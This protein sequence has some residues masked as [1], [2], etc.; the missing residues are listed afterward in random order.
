MKSLKHVLFIFGLFLILSI[1]CKKEEASNIIQISQT[2]A[3][4]FKIVASL[5][6]NNQPKDY[7]WALS[8]NK[9]I[10]DSLNTPLDDNILVPSNLL[11][12]FKIPN[13]KVIVTGKKYINKNHALTSPEIRPGF[14]YSFEIIEIK[15]DL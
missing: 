15:I 7:S 12:E 9:D 11:D 8:T 2:E 13:L 1:S 6:E 14:G 5:D 3:K 10:F 4:V